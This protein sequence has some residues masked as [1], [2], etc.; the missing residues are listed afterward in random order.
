MLLLLL[1]LQAKRK[2]VKPNDIDRNAHPVRFSLAE[3]RLSPVLQE[4]APAL[5]GQALQRWAVLRLWG[6]WVAA[7]KPGCKGRWPVG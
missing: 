5:T 4:Q 6:S 2:I 7:A 1:L 3:P